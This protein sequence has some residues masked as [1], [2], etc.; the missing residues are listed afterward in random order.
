MLLVR[1][2]AERVALLGG[3]AAAAGPAVRP[4]ALTLRLRRL[5]PFGLGLRCGCGG[6]PFGLGVGRLFGLGLAAV[7]AVRPAVG[8]GCVRGWSSGIRFTVRCCGCSADRFTL[9]LAPPWDPASEPR[10]SSAERGPCPDQRR[11]S[12]QSET[13]EVSLWPARIPWCAFRLEHPPRWFPAFAAPR[14]IA[15]PLAHAERAFV[16]LTGPPAG[17]AAD[18]LCSFSDRQAARRPW[19]V[20]A[21]DVASLA[22]MQ[23][24][25]RPGA[26][27]SQILVIAAI[28]EVRLLALF[29]P[30]VLPML[31]A[32]VSV[33]RIVAETAGVDT[34]TTGRTPRCGSWRRSSRRSSSVDIAAARRDGWRT[35]PGR[36]PSSANR[37]NPAAHTRPH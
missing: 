19:G 5:A 11:A 25:G 7:P 26:R 27:R 18:C 10:T 12:P 28:L 33:N 29:P 30:T 8:C 21:L 16:S 37:R 2:A 15:G 17:I 3:C 32:V 14:G 34:N 20:L 1:I 13:R 4:A 9:G 31:P 36:S 22:F 35:R 24:L 23:S 6:R